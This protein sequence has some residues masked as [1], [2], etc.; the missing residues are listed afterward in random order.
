MSEI[1][2]SWTFGSLMSPCGVPAPTAPLRSLHE[3]GGLIWTTSGP[4]QAIQLAEKEA[5]SNLTRSTRVLHREN[6]GNKGV[7]P[8]WASITLSLVSFSI[9]VC[10]DEHRNILKAKT[11]S[12]QKPW[13]CLVTACNQIGLTLTVLVFFVLNQFG[14]QK[15]MWDSS[16]D[17]VI[18]IHIHFDEFHCFF[19]YFGSYNTSCISK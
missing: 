4:H 17:H 2:L 15:T 6:E 12:R 9:K 10:P 3:T 13:G 18:L 7:T 1:N 19:C 8:G 14:L 5:W 11:T 16:L